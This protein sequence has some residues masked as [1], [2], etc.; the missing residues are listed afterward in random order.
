MMNRY[1]SFMVLVLG[2]ALVMGCATQ[3]MS[4]VSAAA[5][6][7]PPVLTPEQQADKAEARQAY[8]GCLKQAAHFAEGR[9]IAAG[10][11]AEVIAPMCYAQFSRYEIAAAAGMDGH[12]WRQFDRDGDKRQLDFAAE[13]IRQEHGL[14][15][16]SPDK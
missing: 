13:A 8:M 1:L 6:D 14:A 2:T 9:A 15:A 5:P 10:D 16:L 11:V 4:Q 3:G 7:A 12:A